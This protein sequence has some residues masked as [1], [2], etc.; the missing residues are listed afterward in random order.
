V[1]TGWYYTDGIFKAN[2]HYDDPRFI[3]TIQWMLDMTKKGFI[4]PYEAT[5]IGVSP[6]DLFSSKKTA[7]VFDGSWM[8]GYYSKSV[9]FPVAFVK[10]PIGPVGRKSMT[11]GLADSIWSGSQHKEEA[12]RWIKYLASV[13]AETQEA[14]AKGGTFV[15]PVLDH[16]IKVSE[17]M[18]EAFDSIF[19]GKAK[20]VDAL[21]AANK[22]VN[23]LF[24]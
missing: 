8:I 3:Q 2:Y 14:L 17:I 20:V 1:S 15:Y 18:T 13:E 12:W 5:N 4:A 7:A 16:G 6:T 9:D 21:I 22:K 10:L 24:N 23:E 19:L 11:N